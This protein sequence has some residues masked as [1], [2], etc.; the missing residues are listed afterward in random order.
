MT[1]KPKKRV[2]T[3]WARIYKTGIAAD[4]Y[5]THFHA[6]RITKRRKIEEWK[7]KELS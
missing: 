5:D 6:M 2:R 4:L 3:Y 1:R 7:N